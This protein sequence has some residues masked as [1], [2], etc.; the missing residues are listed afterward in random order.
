MKILR[1]ITS[2]GAKFFPFCTSKTYFFYFTH[3]FLQNTHISLSILQDI[4][5]KYYFFSI[6]LLLFSTNFPYHTRPLFLSVSLI[7]LIHSSFSIPISL[8]LSTDHLS[9]SLFYLL[10]FF[11]KNNQPNR[12]FHQPRRSEFFTTQ[13]L[14]T[15]STDL[16]TFHSFS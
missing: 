8:P 7:F 11:L 1:A 12:P 3:S 15:Q 13:K 2:V 4:L 10:S 9:L 5:I 14:P 16:R 6:F